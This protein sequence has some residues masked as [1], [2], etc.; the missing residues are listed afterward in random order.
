MSSLG[1][2]VTG[3]KTSPG[4]VLKDAIKRLLLAKDVVL[5]LQ[6]YS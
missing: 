5:A 3:A 2:Y 4:L 1:V 6:D